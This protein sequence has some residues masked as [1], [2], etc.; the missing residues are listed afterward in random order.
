MINTVHN[1][2]CMQL[3]KDTPDKYYQ[4]AIVDPPY[5]IG[6]NNNIGRRKGN[7]RSKYKKIKWDNEPPSTEYFMELFRVRKTK[8]FGVL[9]IFI[10]HLRNVL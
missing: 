6:I 10:C 8:L 5:G 4:L 1:I 9:I 7:K 3:L 2:D